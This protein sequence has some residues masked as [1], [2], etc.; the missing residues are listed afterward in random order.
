MSK[1]GRKEKYL[2][3]FITEIIGTLGATKLKILMMK[4][5]FPV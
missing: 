4:Y 3:F 5:L 2:I 1:D